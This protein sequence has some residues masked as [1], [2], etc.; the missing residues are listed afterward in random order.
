MFSSVTY[1][2]SDI[3]SDTGFEVIICYEMLIIYYAR[4][5]QFLNG[6]LNKNMPEAN[7]LGLII[8]C[9]HFLPPNP[10]TP[11]SCVI[12]NTTESNELWNVIFNLQ[13]KHYK[14]LARSESLLLS[15]TKNFANSS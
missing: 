13:R 14:Y 12:R 3:T 7:K 9:L 1:R 4:L 2:I 6:L 11:L 10:T 15:S 8:R 5:T